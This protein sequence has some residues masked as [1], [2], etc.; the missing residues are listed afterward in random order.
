MSTELFLIRHGQTLWNQQRRLQGQ[1]DSP[2]TEEGLKQAGKLAD[3][4]ADISFD[5]I[6]SSDLGRTMLTARIISAK[7]QGQQLYP[8][9]RLRERNFGIFHGLNWEEIMRRF[10][11]EG[12]KEQETNADYVIPEG[13][14]RKQVLNRCLSFVQD[15]AF[16]HQGKKILAITHGGIVS[17]L[18]RYVLNIPFD[19]PRRFYL[20]NAAVNIFE[21]NE[22]EWFL[23]TLGEISFHE[24]EDLSDGIQ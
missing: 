7:L 23:K 21:Y 20:P 4:L 24:E 11:E 10:P 12:L 16:K 14:S 13:E 18:V 6:Y 22:K 8:D 3:R 9:I 19:V 2:L 1:M 5:A 15:I 17:S